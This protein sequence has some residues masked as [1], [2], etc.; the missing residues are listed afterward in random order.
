MK[1]QRMDIEIVLDE[2][3]QGTVKLNGEDVGARVKSVQLFGAATEPT[4]LILK[5]W[6]SSVRVTAPGV[7]VTTEEAETPTIGGKE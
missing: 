2:H 7:H 1:E 3:S 6:P 5:V 4:Y